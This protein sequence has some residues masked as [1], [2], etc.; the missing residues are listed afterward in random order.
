MTPAEQG[1][2]DLPDGYQ[3]RPLD[4]GAAEAVAAAYDRNRE[5]LAPW[6]PERR[7]D[8]YTVEGQE[9]AL[10][11]QISLIEGKVGAGWLL[12]H[13]DDVV[14]RVNLSNLILG[15]L[16]SCSVG[17]WVDRDHL[18]RGLAVALVEHACAGA[19]GLGMHRVE[20]GTLRHNA[21]S[22]SALRK[23]GFEH[24]GMAP[25]ML[26]IAGRWQDHDLFQRVLHD[27]PPS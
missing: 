20:A 4:L 18:G 7:E 10:V 5:H 6:D 19:V 15:V 21:A 2:P 25:R 9:L 22:Q 16:R 23:A 26:F 13:D 27:D 8:F 3:I 24:Y 11:Q 12:W 1:S 17:Y 14:G